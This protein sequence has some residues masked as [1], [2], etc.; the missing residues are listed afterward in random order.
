MDVG[1]RRI[2]SGLHHTPPAQILPCPSTASSRRSERVVDYDASAVHDVTNA[3]NKNAA[4]GQACACDRADV[5]APHVF[6]IV[7][8]GERGREDVVGKKIRIAQRACRRRTTTC[9]QCKGN[10]TRAIK[11]AC[12][13]NGSPAKKGCGEEACASALATGGTGA[14]AKVD[15]DTN[16]PDCGIW[17]AATAIFE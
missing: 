17:R 12:Q 13:G 14:C 11:P 16:H 7:S 8:L 4:G 2:R 5:A 1:K 15:I 6:H 9:S 10:S 3:P